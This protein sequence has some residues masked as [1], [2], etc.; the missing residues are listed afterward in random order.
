MALHSKLINKVE[1][2]DLKSYYSSRSFQLFIATFGIFNTQTAT[3]KYY[4][5]SCI[6]NKGEIILTPDVGKASNFV[7]G[8]VGNLQLFG[9][10]LKTAEEGL[11]WAEEFKMKWESGSNDLLSEVRDKKLDEILNK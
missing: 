2:K 6:D 8:T 1:P 5:V 11:K 10:E 4:L 7:N 3:W 9:R